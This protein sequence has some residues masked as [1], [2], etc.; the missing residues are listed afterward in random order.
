MGLQT[1]CTVRNFDGI[2]NGVKQ[3]IISILMQFVIF[4]GSFSAPTENWFPYLK[5][6]L[7]ILKQKV[8]VPQFPIENFEQFTKSGPNQSSKIQNL[9]NWTRCF[10]NILNK[11]DKNDK[12]CFVGHS[13]GCVFILHLVEKFNIRL[14]S[15]FFVA[16]FLTLNKVSWQYDLVNRTF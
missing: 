7:E 14:D 4:H 5:R 8:A 6:N 2:L 10:E 12:L 1:G 15:A 13:I 11:F 9:T 16:P 3:C